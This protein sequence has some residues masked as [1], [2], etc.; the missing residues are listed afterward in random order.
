MALIISLVMLTFL[1]IMGLTFISVSSRD[2]VYARYVVLRT[3]AYY[4][5]EAGIEYAQ[6]SRINWTD[7]PHTEEFEYR[8]GKIS[9]EVNDLGN[10]AVEITS[11]GKYASFRQG[12]KVIYGQ[13]G[14]IQSWEEL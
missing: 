3:Q 1:F 13:D 7:Y 9:I 14:T 12:I 6:I 2:Y 11:Y 8:E 5:A 10:G 4:M